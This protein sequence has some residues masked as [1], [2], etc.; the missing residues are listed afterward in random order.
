VVVYDED[1]EFDYF[2]ETAEVGHISFCGLP[3][4]ALLIWEGTAR[5]R[6][7]LYQTQLA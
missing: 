6:T 3:R 4:D 7:H 5:G 1:L 2:L